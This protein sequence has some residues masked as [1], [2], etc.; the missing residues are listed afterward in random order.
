M[1]RRRN[2]RR[3]NTQEEIVWKKWRRIM[4][5]QEDKWR[6]DTYLHAAIF[7]C[8]VEELEE[9]MRPE[10]EKISGARGAIQNQSGDL[11][12]Q[13]PSLIQPRAPDL[14]YEAKNPPK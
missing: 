8:E 6:Y 4:Q 9:R 2:R 13:D 11:R 1:N 7:S 14:I 5:S 3:A 10:F 12:V